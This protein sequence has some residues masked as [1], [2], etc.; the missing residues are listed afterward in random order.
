MYSA[1]FHVLSSIHRSYYERWILDNTWKPAEYIW[2]IFYS[3]RPVDAYMRRWM[4]SSLEQIIICRMFGKLK[5]LWH[6]ISMKHFDKKISFKKIHS[7]IPCEKL[8]PFALASMCQYLNNAPQNMGN[9]G[10]SSRRQIFISM[11]QD[12][13]DFSIKT[14]SCQYKN[15]IVET[16]QWY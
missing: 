11:W 1:G 5:Q 10:I 3:L 6:I 7:K 4:G 2:L 16:R 15:A 9:S 8:R 14:P 13:P 12:H